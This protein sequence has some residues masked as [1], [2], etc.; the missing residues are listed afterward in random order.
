MMPTPGG[1]PD[2]AERQRGVGRGEVR[3]AHPGAAVA[4]DEERLGRPGRDGPVGDVDQRRPPVDL[5]HAGVLHRTRD[6]DEGR[7][8]V[9]DE[10]VGPEGVGA[11]AGDHRHVRQRLGVVH[12]RAPAPDAQGACP[13]PG[14]RTGGTRP[15]STQRASADS[16]PATKRS[17]GRTMTS[18]TG[19]QPVA[20]RSSIARATAEATWWRP[21]GTQTVTLR[22]RRWPRPGAVRRRAPGAATG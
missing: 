15:D 11:G 5:H 10:P 6:R 4:A 18:G 12:Q 20:T 22:A 21:S 16:S 8:G 2:G 13:C 3:R 17:G 19:A 9:L 7:P 14:G 1:G